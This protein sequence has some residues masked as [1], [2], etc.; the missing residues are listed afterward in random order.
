MGCII[1]TV[2]CIMY[3]LYSILCTVHCVLYSIVI[4]YTVTSLCM[5]DVCILTCT[6]HRVLILLCFTMYIL[7]NKVQCIDTTW[8]LIV[9]GT[10]Y[11][12]QYLTLHCVQYIIVYCIWYLIMV[13][14]IQFQNT[15][16]LLYSVQCTLYNYIEHHH[17][18]SVANLPYLENIYMP[19]N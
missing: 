11:C 6:D 13:Y 17:N 15:M 4:C 16:Y 10:S 14:Y 5:Y 2:Y 12:V 3:T 19:I 18:V 9:F 1:Y 8:Y 7:F